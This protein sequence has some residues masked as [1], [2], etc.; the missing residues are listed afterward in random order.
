MQDSGHERGCVG[1]CLG[2]PSWRRRPR[3][4]IR[5]DSRTFTFLTPGQLYAVV[6]TG[7][8]RS[9]TP[10]NNSSGSLSA[11]TIVGYHSLHP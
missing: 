6:S 2:V 4:R 11:A 7:R 8:M 10:D 1:V 9:P 3:L 5:Q